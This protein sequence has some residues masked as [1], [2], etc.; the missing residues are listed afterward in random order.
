MTDGCGFVNLAALLQIASPLGFTSWNTA[1]QGCIMGAKGMWLL[2]PDN[3]L[4]TTEPKIWIWDLQD[5][6]KLP[7]LVTCDRGHLILDFVTPA[8]MISPRRLSA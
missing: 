3:L 8:R 5:K 1:F 6:I 7:D 4:S 2:H